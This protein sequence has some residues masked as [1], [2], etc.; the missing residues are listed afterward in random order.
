[1]E[2]DN[3]AIIK[4]ELS[5]ANKDEF[6]FLQIL[7]RNKDGHKD[8]NGRNKNRLIKS[9]YIHSVEELEKHKEKIKE[10]CVNNGARAYI[11]LNVLCVLPEW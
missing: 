9:Y 3:F 6:Y 8:V 10:L 4:K 2:V 1:M 11:N 7:Q 5:F